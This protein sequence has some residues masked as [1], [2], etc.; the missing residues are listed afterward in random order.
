MIEVH[1]LQAIMLPALY[2]RDTLFQHAKR[3]EMVV[4]PPSL[5]A[6][7][8]ISWIRTQ[9]MT[10]CTHEVTLSNLGQDGGPGNVAFDHSRDLSNFLSPITMV[11]VHCDTRKEPPTIE[12]RRAF[13]DAPDSSIPDLTTLFIPRHHRLP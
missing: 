13:F 7:A 5:V 10:V 3:F 12:T 1:L 4:K 8:S 11:K 2:T 9:P 6:L